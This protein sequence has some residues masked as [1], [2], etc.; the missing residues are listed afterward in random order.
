MLPQGWTFLWKKMRVWFT[1]P[2]MLISHYGPKTGRGMV[3]PR[4]FPL[5]TVEQMELLWKLCKRKRN[6]LMEEAKKVRKESDRNQAEAKVDGVAFT[7]WNGRISVSPS[8]CVWW[9]SWEL[10]TFFL[11]DQNVTRPAYLLSVY[12][13][14]IT[15]EFPR[16][17]VNS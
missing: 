8:I 17:V 3:L 11:L 12:A 13:A 7:R 14:F 9:V 4:R 10:K 5:A 2:R 6:R 16:P 15:T 1:A